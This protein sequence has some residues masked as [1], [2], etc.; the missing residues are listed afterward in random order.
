VVRI[1]AKNAQQLR[2]LLEA[3]AEDAGGGVAPRFRAAAA[4]LAASTSLDDLA[5]VALVLVSAA[6]TGNV[7][8]D[9]RRDV[10]LWTKVVAGWLESGR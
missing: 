7:S 4:R 9:H 2:A 6:E 3:V 10:C 5:T 1:G 8:A